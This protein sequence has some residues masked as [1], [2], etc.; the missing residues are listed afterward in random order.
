MFRILTLSNMYPSKSNRNSGIFIHK[1]VKY[2]TGEGCRFVVISPNAFSPQFL[3]FNSKWRA[4]GHIPLTDEI[5]GITVNY[6]RYL[7]IPGKL[8][9]GLS[10]YSLYYG[11]KNFLHQI[12]EDF[13]PHL[14]HAHAATPMGYVGLMLRKKYHLPLVCSLRGSD[15]HTY[16][17]F[18]KQSML[19]TKKVLS[20]ADQLVSVSN[21]L[22]IEAETIGQAKKE[23]AVV[24]NGCDSGTF[25]NN[26]GDGNAIRMKMGISAQDKVIIFVGGISKGKGVYELVEAFINLSQKY[27]HLQLILVGSGQESATINS[28][29]SSIGLANRIHMTGS[30]HHDEIS[31]WLSA[32]DIF[33]FPSHNEGLPNAVLEAM[34]CGL[35]V[36]ATRVGGIPEAI[37]D[38]QSGILI[39]EKDADSLI[40]AIDRL[41]GNEE[42]AKQMGR[43]GRNMVEQNFSWEKNAEQMI[44]IYREVIGR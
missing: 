39:K 26:E 9:H 41:L 14:I 12:I 15:I 13:K 18:G 6:P 40:R 4:Y 17:K 35:P 25:I 44:R 2:L 1:Q 42:L 38:G 21:A 11:A 30:L 27:Q 16:P 8:F 3:W 43:N 10:C 19:L 7:R 36:V 22:K 23:I 33:V 34:A 32:A 5:E 31:Q 20:E 29:V 37:E 28:I 24:H